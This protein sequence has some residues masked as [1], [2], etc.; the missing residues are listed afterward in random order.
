MEVYM[1]KGKRYEGEPKLNLKKVFA[2]IIAIAVI[3][4]FVIGIK[5]LMT[6][7]NKTDEKL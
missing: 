2:V 3:V 1:S 6:P 4:M 5:K 7:S